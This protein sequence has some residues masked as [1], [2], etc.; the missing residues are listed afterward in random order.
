MK[1]LQRLKSKK[2]FSLVE[3]L[4]VIAIM[5][6]LVGILAPQYIRYVERSRQSADIQVVNS[7]ATAIRT[8]SLDTMYEEDMP[9]GLGATITVTWASNGNG[10]II[11]TDAA[12]GTG[13]AAGDTGAIAES[14]IAI[15]GGTSVGNTGN[16]A[17]N[18]NS[19]SNLAGSFVTELVFTFDADG[20]GRI[21]TVRGVGETSSDR[22]S[23]THA[24]RNILD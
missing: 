4:I 19:R 24:L 17:G 13:G 15:I 23:W 20:G 16:E 2:G 14:I 6:V 7:I 1:K 8:T 3:L 11:V 9:T 10:D 12:A 21:T 22:G 5:A 18:A